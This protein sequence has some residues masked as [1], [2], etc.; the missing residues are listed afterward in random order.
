MSAVT[1]EGATSFLIV[2]SPDA[3]V[4]LAATP[5]SADLTDSPVGAAAL[6]TVT[7]VGAELIVMPVVVASECTARFCAAFEKSDGADEAMLAS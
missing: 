6:D 4:M 1:P 2:T 3:I 5:V 7:P